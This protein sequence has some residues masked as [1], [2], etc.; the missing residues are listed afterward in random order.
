[1]TPPVSGRVPRCLA[2]VWY[3]YS[4]PLPVAIESMFVIVI[5]KCKIGGKMHGVLPSR[6]TNTLLTS[7][8]SIAHGYIYFLCHR[9]VKKEMPFMMERET[10][11]RA[12]SLLDIS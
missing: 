8:V 10:I 4:L 6:S 2:Q 1:M 3:H 7:L 12:I 9:L 11:S 5:F